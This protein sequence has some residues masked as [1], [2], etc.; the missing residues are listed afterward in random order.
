MVCPKCGYEQQDDRKSC[1]RC[2]LIFS[3][4][5]ETPALPVSV[6]DQGDSQELLESSFG[7]RDLILPCP[8]DVN[9]LM[10]LVWAAVMLVLV[11]WGGKLIFAGVASNAAGESVLHLVN[12]P[13]HEAGHVIF[14]PFGQF[15]RT[16]GGSLGQL[17][18]PLVCMVALLFKT[19]DPFGAAVCLWWFGE[20]F[21]DLAPYINDARAGQLPLLGGNFGDSSPYGFHDWNYLLNETGLLRYDHALAWTSQFFGALIMLLAVGWIVSLLYRQYR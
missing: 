20:N 8:A 2:G 18:V 17:L 19:R 5:R 12:L 14:R 21:L 1:L 16:L 15:V 6:T 11:L 13:F 10:L 3:K 7:W 4:F 9:S